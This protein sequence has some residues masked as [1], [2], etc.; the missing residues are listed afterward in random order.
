MKLEKSKMNLLLAKWIKYDKD[1]WRALR[2]IQLKILYERIIEERSYQELAK[3]YKVSESKIK[4]V[5]TGIMLRIEKDLGKGVAHSLR[6]IN[7]KIEQ[8]E[9]GKN[10]SGLKMV[11]YFKPIYLN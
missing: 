6:E 5:F 9:N 1:L 2:N 4:A 8:E 7:T 3:I 11:L 10:G